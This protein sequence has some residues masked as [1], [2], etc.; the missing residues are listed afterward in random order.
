MYLLSAPSSVG[1]LLRPLPSAGLP[2]LPPGLAAAEPGLL[3]LPPPP[4]SSLPAPGRPGSPR[5]REEGDEP[6]DVGRLL[7]RLLLLLPP[8]PSPLLLPPPPCA[9]AFSMEPA[10]QGPSPP[11]RGCCEFPG[12]A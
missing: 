10:A 1:S 7:L 11:G 9:A 8:P 3:L 4:P 6:A 12:N 5:P 2:P